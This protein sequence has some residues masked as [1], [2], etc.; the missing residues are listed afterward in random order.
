MTIPA[1]F[2]A[3]INYLLK[4]CFLKREGKKPDNM[5][6]SF[7]IFFKLLRANRINQF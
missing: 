1:F 4:I 5:C 7:D 6:K 2:E 3:L